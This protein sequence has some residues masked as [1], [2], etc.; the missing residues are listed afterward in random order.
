MKR[1]RALALVA[2]VL[3]LAACVK[4]TTNASSGAYGALPLA[5]ATQAPAPSHIVNVTL[6]KTDPDHMFIHLSSDSALSGLV[7]FIVKN[8]DTEKHEFVVLKTGTPAANFPVTSFEGESDRF[9]EDTAGTN[10]GETGD[11]AAGTAK[12]L[13]I[14]LAPGHYAVVCNL[15]GHYRMGMHQDFTVVPANVVNI[16]L[17]QSDA[18]HMFIHLS[19]SATPSGKTT[20]HV[21]NTDNV[22]HEF[23]VLKTDTPAANF[24]VTSFE[25]E[26]DRFD[27]DAAGTNVG[28][29]GDMEAGV[30]KDLVINLKPGH[31]AVV[32][33]LPGHYR[34]G[35]HQDFTVVDA[36]RITVTE[37]E[38]S[39]SAMFINVSS[40]SAPRGRVTFEITNNGVNT[41]EFVVLQTETAASAFPIV[42]FE[43]ESDRFNEDKVGVNVGET[44]DMKPG[45]TKALTIALK[46]GHYALVCNLPGH[47]RMGM[48]LDFVVV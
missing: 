4:T 2:A 13:T 1:A 28:E 27:E 39:M 25:G 8:A 21:T 22:K 16:A 20:F 33:N 38:S 11:M 47:Y 7:S 40:T 5:D 36:S 37:G 3:V 26:A 30:V 41:H 12:A 43:G 14:R 17:G 48:H 34:M 45:E 44:G 29:T 15:P 19:S 23:V 42:G 46:P 18:A 35:M 31:Y 9:N 6:G 24:P 10:V 32:C